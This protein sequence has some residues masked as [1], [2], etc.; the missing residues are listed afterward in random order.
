MCGCIFYSLAPCL[1]SRLLATR[2]DL[3][4][5]PEIAWDTLGHLRAAVHAL[6]VLPGGCHRDL[7]P[8]PR[9]GHVQHLDLRRVRLVRPGHRGSRTLLPFRQGKS[10]PPRR[11]NPESWRKNKNR[12]WLS[13]F[14]FR[15]MGGSDWY[16]FSSSVLARCECQAK[17]TSVDGGSRILGKTNQWH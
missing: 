6:P 7:S 17:T 4:P 16:S 14:G 13:G 9:P 12:I 15:A 2:F 5:A 8:A 11:L 1:A 10:I 3:G